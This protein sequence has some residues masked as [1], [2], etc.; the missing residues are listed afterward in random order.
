MR[1]AR[2][3][4]TPLAPLGAR[5]PPAAASVSASAGRLPVAPSA[6]SAVWAW[7][8]GAPGHVAAVLCLRRVPGQPSSLRPPCAG[9]SR[10]P[11]RWLTR[12]GVD[13]LQSSRAPGGFPAF[14]SRPARCQLQVGLGLELCRSSQLEEHAYHSPCFV[15]NTMMKSHMRDS[16]LNLSVWGQL[17]HSHA[18]SRPSTAERAWWPRVCGIRAQA[19]LAL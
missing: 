2:R 1:A 9:T 7:R 5:L 13:M 3:A 17:P 6:L 14:P 15:T 10:R 8:T 16:D 19:L 11:A 12:S 4:R 18:A